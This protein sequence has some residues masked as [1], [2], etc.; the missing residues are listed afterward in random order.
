MQMKN[1]LKPSEKNGAGYGGQDPREELGDLTFLNLFLTSNEV[2]FS[3][4]KR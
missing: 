1:T 2:R 4:K 3:F